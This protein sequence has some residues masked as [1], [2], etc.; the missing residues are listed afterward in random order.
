MRLRNGYAPS[1]AA[2]GDFASDCLLQA[3]MAVANVSS[4]IPARPTTSTSTFSHTNE[5]T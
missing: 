3:P 4:P 2:L 1:F 5:F